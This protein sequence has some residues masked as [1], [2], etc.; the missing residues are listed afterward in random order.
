M[1]SYTNSI[2]CRLIGYHS[3]MHF[4]FIFLSNL[5]ETFLFRTALYVSITEI[6]ETTAAKYYKG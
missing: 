6:T 1:L 2:A 3:E 5:C 4:I